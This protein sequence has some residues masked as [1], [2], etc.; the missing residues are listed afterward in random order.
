M[1]LVNEFLEQQLELVNK[2]LI[3]AETKNMLV[4]AYSGAMLGLNFAICTHRN[5]DI[6]LIGS[7]GIFA[8]SI[9]VA[10]SSFLPHLS[11]KVGAKDKEQLDVDFNPLYFGDVAKASDEDMLIECIQKKYFDNKGKVDNKTSDLAREL[12]INAS[13]AMVK[14]NKFTWALRLSVIGFVWFVVRFLYLVLN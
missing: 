5:F 10:L 1:S 13:I 12:I 4:V 3:L 11:N 6:G 7:L 9:L 8:M 2:W 14:Y